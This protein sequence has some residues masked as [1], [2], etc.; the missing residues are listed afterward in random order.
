M[1]NERMV[2]FACLPSSLFRP[3][4]GQQIAVIDNSNTMGKST[5]LLDMGTE[6]YAA[7][8]LNNCFADHAWI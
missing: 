5:T 3:F 6:K 8:L 7:L 1:I 2:S 4:L